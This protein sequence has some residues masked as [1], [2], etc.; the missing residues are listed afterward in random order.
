MPDAPSAAPKKAGSDP[1]EAAA[2]RIENAFDNAAP[3]NTGAAYRQLL[4]EFMK[5]DPQTA[6]KIW[7]QIGADDLKNKDNVQEFLAATWG[8][9]SLAGLE[10]SNSLNTMDP[11]TLQALISKDTFD[12]GG[13]PMTQQQVTDEVAMLSA[14]YIS[15][16]N[17]YTNFSEFGI[18][19][20]PII[21]ADINPSG[22]L[23]LNKEEGWNYQAPPDPPRPAWER[24]LIWL[25]G[26]WGDQ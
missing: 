2:K 5:V 11:S 3:E 25:D 14:T 4:D 10:G 15:D 24:A 8:F 26:G 9:N 17:H 23:V 19:N 21:A 16:I 1:I 22:T 13:K 6:G 12:T 18:A 20:E 7:K